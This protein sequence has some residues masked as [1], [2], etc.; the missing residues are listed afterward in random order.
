MRERSF[1][2]HDLNTNLSELIHE[3]LRELFLASKK[4]AVYSGG[5]PLAQKAISRAFVMMDKIFRFKK[6][7]HLHISQGHLYALNIRTRPSIFTDQIMDYMQI[8]DLNDILIDAKITANELA[9]FL[10]RFVRR[11][12][13][14][15]YRNLMKTYLEEKGIDAV[16]VNAEIGH[17]MFERNPQWRGDIAD[18]FSLRA[19]V[20]QVIGNDFED[21]VTLIVDQDLKCEDYLSRHNHDYYPALVGYLIPERIAALE[22]KD[23]VSLLSSRV[24]EIMGEGTDLDEIDKPDLQKLK[25]LISALNYHP[26]REA[27]I[28]EIGSVLLER[29]I[30]KE[31]YS[32]ILPQVSAIKIESLEKIDQF[33]YATFNQAL[34]GF[35]L[36]D[37]KEL[38]SRLLRT[39]QQGKVRSVINILMNHLAGSNLDLRQKALVLFKHAISV[40]SKTTSHFLI[41]HVISKIDEYVSDARETFEFSDLTWE[42]AMITLAVKDYKHLSAIC[43]ILAQRRIQDKGLWIYESISVKKSVD[44]LNR[45]EVIDQLVQDLVRDSR[46]DVQ[47]IR[48]ILITIGSEEAALALSSIISHESR[49]VRQHVLKILAEMGKATLNVFTRVL[50]DNSYFD[51][52]P[53]KRELSDEKWYVV[54]N[55]IFV[56]GSLKDPEGCRALRVRIHDG[57]TRVRHAIIQSLEKIGGEQAVDLLLILASDPDKMIRETAIIALGFVGTQD[58]VPELIDLANKCRS[59][60]INIITTIGMLGGTEARAF[61]R[62]LLNDQQ[63]QSQLTSSRSSRDDLKLATIKA[64]G[65]IG[66]KESLKEIK[67][68]SDSLSASQKVLFGGS[69]LNKVAEDILNKQNK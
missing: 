22:P 59:E 66:D 48:N 5:H 31:I 16:I 38:F 62:E 34:P 61:L 28:D 45:R 32:K 2:E 50:M 8:L 40:Y 10:E 9:L 42:L 17:C 54:R 30:K 64:L 1:T 67:D 24:S 46:S 25:N 60:I 35:Q 65:R 27:I 29:G 33:L 18:D 20:N 7:F 51:R 37:F 47:Y 6:Y 12:P 4:I 69:K 49:H 68:F 21:L 15:D 57:D 19:I 53:N 52:D 39:G 44:E 56:L 3:T 23:I 11:L 14:T 41:E 55:S 63:L 26:H 43:D 13:S 36:D 58:I